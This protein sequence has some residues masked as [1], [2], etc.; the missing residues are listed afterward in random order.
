MSKTYKAK[1]IDLHIG[2]A[3]RGINMSAQL[4]IPVHTQSTNETHLFDRS[5]QTKNLLVALWKFRRDCMKYG[6]RQ[7]KREG[8]FDITPSNF[9][10]GLLWT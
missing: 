10:P 7:Q 6:E 4:S 2:V 1:I 8:S 5:Y 3:S 9:R